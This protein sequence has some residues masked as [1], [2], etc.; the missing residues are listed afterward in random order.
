MRC[1]RRRIWRGG[2]SWGLGRDRLGN[3]R[4]AGV[5]GLSQH[6]LWAKGKDQD[7]DED[8]GCCILGHWTAS[9]LLGPRAIC[10]QGPCYANLEAQAAIK[11]RTIASLAGVGVERDRSITITPGDRAVDPP[12][13]SRNR[14]IFGKPSIGVAARALKKRDSE[15]CVDSWKISNYASMYIGLKCFHQ[16][17]STVFMQPR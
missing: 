8:L 15:K 12:T 17:H 7:Q 11:F 16:I 2:I 4:W 3:L 10:G 6:V 1:W 14:V 9:D 5:A 13:L